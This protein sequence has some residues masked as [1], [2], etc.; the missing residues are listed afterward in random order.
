MIDDL[1]CLI[2]N[3]YVQFY[4]IEIQQRANSKMEKEKIQNV[5]KTNK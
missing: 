4:S 5:G 2:G 3:R 1:I